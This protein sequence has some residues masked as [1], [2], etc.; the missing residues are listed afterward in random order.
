MKVYF[1]KTETVFGSI[2]Y[3]ICQK[4]TQE[5]S[6]ALNERHIWTKCS[7]QWHESGAS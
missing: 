6:T 3:I 4:E 1:N 7:A 5:Q 2:A